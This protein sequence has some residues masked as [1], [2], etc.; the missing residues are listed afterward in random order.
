MRAL[1]VGTRKSPLAMKQTE[2]VIKALKQVQ[3]LEIEIVGIS[4]KGDRLQKAPLS[5]IGGKGVFVKEVESQLQERKIDFAVH[6]LKDVPAMIPHDLVIAAMPK[7]ANPFDFFVAAEKRQLSNEPLRVGT[8]SLRR[9]HQLKAAFPKMTFEPI[10]GNIETRMRK[11]NEQGLDGTILAAAGL[12]RMGYLE[13]LRG[14][15]LTPERCVPAV[16]QGVLGIQCRR[17]DQDLLKLLQRINHPET[18]QA[19]EAERHFLRA[20]NGNCDV[21]IGAYAEKKEQW[22]FWAFS[23]ASAEAVGR[24]IKLAGTDP[25]ELADRAAKELLQ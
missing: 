18:A 7:R 9:V 1:R 21:P 11:M 4:T 5:Q 19:A 6:S 22:E 24:R 12:E 13:G 2:I 8:S 20:A 25:L 10:R 14:E 17:E 16:G 15:L 23:A 3:S